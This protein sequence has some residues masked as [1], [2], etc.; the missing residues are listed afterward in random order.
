MLAVIATSML[1]LGTA[2]VTPVASASAAAAAPPP[3]HPDVR[4]ATRYALRRHGTVSFSVRTRDGD[5]PVR[6]WGFRQ[7][8]AAQS[9][10][11]IKAMLLMCYLR[12]RDV[13]DRPLREDEEELPAARGG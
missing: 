4:A 3:W 13:R 10:S 12:R 6:V 7:D 1:A 8:R 2:S 9:A 11:V 5:G